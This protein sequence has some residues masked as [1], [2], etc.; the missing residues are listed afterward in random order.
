[1]YHIIKLNKKYLFHFNISFTSIR[2][3]YISIWFPFRSIWFP[4]GSIWFPFG[5]H[6]GPFGSI[7]VFRR[8]ENW[9]S[10][11]KMSKRSYLRSLASTLPK[12]AQNIANHLRYIFV[13][14]SFSMK[15]LFTL[16]KETVI[17]YIIIY[18]HELSIS[19]SL[20][21]IKMW[22]FCKHDFIMKSCLQN[23]HILIF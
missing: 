7:W 14:S 1:M 18:A 6:L 15:S 5:F 19:L 16:C 8:T 23:S 11:A 17:F 20:W 22:L 12:E 3:I 4:F 21:N 2:N 13:Q 9:T 10:H